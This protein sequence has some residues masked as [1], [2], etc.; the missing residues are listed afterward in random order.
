[1]SWREDYAERV[2]ESINQ[3]GL[4]VFP[5]KKIFVD[6]VNGSDGNDG[7]V[8]RPVKTLAVAEDMTTNNKNDVVYMI[9]GASAFTLTSAFTWDKSFTHL[10]GVVAPVEYGIRNRILT[11]TASVSPLFLLSGN[12]C[13]MANMM[14]SQEGDHAT[15]NAIALKIT[16]ARNYFKNVTARN[17]SASGVLD[18]SK[19]DVVLNSSNGENV[20]SSC[21]FGTDTY[22]GSANAANFVFEFNGA[23]ETARNKFYDCMFL[24]SG[25]SGASFIKCTTTSATS[26]FQLFKNCVFYNNDNGSMNTMTQA[27]AIDAACGGQFIFIDSWM[28]GASTLQTTNSA[29]FIVQDAAAAATSMKLLAGTY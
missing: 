18:V 24:G 20:F 28:Y 8:T 4:P 16:G 21:T 7:A 13:V 22:D 17:L 11:A 19:R 27:F 3:N 14:I 9:G 12:G 25:S 2:L 15:G 10:I 6:P 23:V 29:N 26:S 1:M 5:G